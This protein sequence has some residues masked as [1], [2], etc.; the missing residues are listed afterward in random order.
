MDYRWVG[1]SQLYDY[2]ERVND[3]FTITAHHQAITLSHVVYDYG[4]RLY[5]Y[6]TIRPS[7]L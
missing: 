5:N 1:A 7:L 2:G 6:L 4:G 3:Y